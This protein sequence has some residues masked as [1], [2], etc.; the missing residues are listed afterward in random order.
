MAHT[1]PSP[2]LEVDPGTNPLRG[3]E[4]E[5]AVIDRRLSAVEAGVGGVLLLQGPSGIG[6]SRLSTEVAARAERAGARVLRAG[7]V[8]GG[9]AP[10]APLL[11]ATLGAVPPVGFG[12]PGGRAGAEYWVLHDLRS[13]LWEAAA[14]GPL[15]IVIDDLHWA[16]AD[17]AI[18]IRTLVSDLRQAGVL[19]V[20]AACRP[21]ADPV[22]G[23]LLTR[24]EADGAEVLHLG[25]LPVSASVGIVADVAG[26]EPQPDLL[27]MAGGLTGHPHPY[28]LVE[29]LRGLHEEG[30]L[31]V[32]GGRAS[33]LGAELPRRVTAAVSERLQALPART[34]RIVRVAA[35]LPPRFTAAQLAGMAGCRPSELIEPLDDAVRA[36]LLAIGGQG[37][38]FT[39]DLLREATRQTMPPS[40]RRVLERESADV[41]LRTGAA[42]AEVA[43]MLARTAEAGDRG[44]IATLRAA[45]ETI[46]TA[47]PGTAADLT[48]RALE[49]LPP[50][51]EGRG[52][53][54]VS[55]LTQ[56]HRAMRTGE[57]GAVAARA[58]GELLPAEQETAV[59]LSLST[60]VA[61][62]AVERI[63][64]N[65]AALALPGAGPR[66]RAE[67][68]GWLAYNLM[69]GGDAPE[70]GRQARAAL[71]EA[72]KVVDPATTAIARLILASALCTRGVGTAAA[73]ELDLLPAHA[74]RP[75]PH[76]PLR[77]LHAA[78]LLHCIGRTAE[79]TAALNDCLRQARRDHDAPL[80]S[81]GTQFSAMINLMTGQL[82][83][84]RADLDGSGP[85]AADDGPVSII[86]VLPMITSAALAQ[87]LGDAVLARAAAA[88]ARRL[89]GSASEPGRRWA[90]RVLSVEAVK[91]GNAVYAARLL[92]DDPL[93]V[94]G[95]PLAVDM[96]HLI[97]A[98][99][100]AG[101]ANDRALAERIAAA[102]EGLEA[103]ADAAPAFAAGAEHVRG[104]LDG[105]PERLL[106]AAARQSAAG[107]PLL[108]ALA[109]E[110]A[111]AVLLRGGREADGAER[112]SAAFDMYNAAGATGDAHRVRAS[113]RAQGSPR[114]PGGDRAGT[115][116]A[117]LTVSELRVVRL[118]AAGATN[119]GAAR[120]LFLSP[121]TV[122]AHVRSVFAKL[123]IKS[124][125]HLA[126]ALR[127]NGG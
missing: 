90:R 120:Q 13:A 32:A 45:A 27:E 14:A 37:I 15:V 4:P 96:A 118:I 110:E 87:H 30:R 49:L 77:D 76:A 114:R 54:L 28:W 126:N 65:R 71:A 1:S 8:R 21:L 40:L 7:A 58:F 16:D 93:L 70:A 113:L 66:A 42:P 51:D 55:A 105:D 5:I 101:A 6:K 62:P 59:R 36:D 119:R 63:E 72:A 104:L 9:A 11:A 85:I 106:S 108:A 91:R 89:R 80:L 94:T 17:T 25:P 3:R 35:L 117:S 31:R 61:R 75:D 64:Q 43:S 82:A 84:A 97:H 48:L 122:N 19:W 81:L 50:D 100:V 121:H 47:D 24:L 123:G 38:R 98:S 33:V 74:G 46:A 88:T 83:A 56:L 73:A 67:H 39:Q 34:R 18:A 127:D 69:A 57:A 60:A 26:A 111:G 78:N 112:L 109:T 41:L 79:A 23:D 44:A 53:L 95:P 99:R 103:G 102:A 124:R 86:T 12:P 125:V 29:L 68:R 10:F 116:W 92:A 115:G 22:I 52:S 107:R 2:V 20:L